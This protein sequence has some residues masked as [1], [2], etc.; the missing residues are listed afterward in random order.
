MAGSHEGS[1]DKYDY[2][3]QGRNWKR[4]KR[5]RFHDW[6][7]KAYPSEKDNLSTRRL[8]EVADEFARQDSD[9]WDD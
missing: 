8:S 5:R 2:A 6:L 3:L 9:R 4:G 1:Q 7:A